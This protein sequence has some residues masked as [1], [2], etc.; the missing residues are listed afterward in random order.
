M[1]RMYFFCATLSMMSLGA[2]AQ[3]ALPLSVDEDV[4]NADTIFV[5]KTRVEWNSSANAVKTEN[6]QDGGYA[7]FKFKDTPGMLHLDY[8]RTKYGKDRVMMIQESPDGQNFSD[9]YNGD[10]STSWTTLASKLKKDTRYIKLYYDAKYTFGDVGSRMAYW[11]DINVTEPIAAQAKADTIDVDYGVKALKTISV[12]YSNP[13]G[14]IIVSSSD[15]RI[16]FGQE[17]SNTFTIANVA[18]TEGTATVDVYYDSS[19]EPVAT[20]EISSVLT[21]AD[22]GNEGYAKEYK[23]VERVKAPVV[24][25]ETEGSIT[26]VVGQ[27]ATKTF[28]V[29]YLPSVSPDNVSVVSSREDVAVSVE[30]SVD[31][32]N[33]LNV[34]LTYLP[35]EVAD[36]AEAKITVSESTSGL[37]LAYNLTVN[38]YS[39]NNIITN[40]AEYNKFAEIVNAGFNVNAELSNDIEFSADEP[41]VQ[42][43]SFA[44]VFDGKFHKINGYG[45][46]DEKALFGN[47]TSFTGTV[48]NLCVENVALLD[49]NVEGLD[50]NGNGLAVECCYGTP[51]DNGNALLMNYVYMNTDKV[52]NC[53]T[54]VRGEEIDPST[55]VGS[56]VYLYKLNDGSLGMLEADMTTTEGMPAC[57]SLWKQMESSAPAVFGFKIGT[58]EMPSFLAADNAVST[59]NYY[60]N[61]ANATGKTI[62]VQGGQLYDETLAS[63]KFEGKKNDFVVLNEDSETLGEDGMKALSDNVVTKDGKAHK[64]VLTDGED[65]RFPVNAS[66][67]EISADSIEYSRSV[68]F[69]SYNE[70]FCLPFDITSS[71]DDS[72]YGFHIDYIFVDPSKPALREDKDEITLQSTFNY[73]TYNAGK[74]GSVIPAGTPFY[75]YCCEVLPTD[76]TVSD[77]EES[78]ATFVGENVSLKKDV[79]GTNGKFAP[80]FGTYVNSS[81]ADLDSDDLLT[82]VLADVEDNAEFM[83][84][85][86]RPA[87]DYSVKAFRVYALL[88]KSVSESGLKSYKVIVDDGKTS[89]IKIVDNE[90]AQSASAVYDL[91]G[92]RVTKM[93]DGN[94]YMQN[95]RKFVFMAK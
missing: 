26:T 68:R 60:T 33:V 42:I 78:V 14:D 91:M 15:S 3:V 45:A 48:K 44:G 40:V 30:P 47:S 92:R 39:A 79:E 54:R 31:A 21:V 1:K 52:K 50:E 38:A 95:G 94:I 17:G 58:D 8:Q 5:E 53:F 93:T 88:D 23:I 55:G 67:Q 20:G 19:L 73:M 4:F 64:I 46:S 57:F 10:P 84:D 90:N 81:V 65:Y 76:G 63:F 18:G 7:V 49:A 2:S 12:S 43:E 13:S 27:E 11:R 37:S 82:Y 75:A 72:K 41:N 89:G 80:L 32:E 85:F 6:F 77:T 35:Q 28:S 25:S 9:L 87:T 61:E 34:T 62:Y 83:G 51:S 70:S 59:A 71:D 22:S 16:S 24:L 86:V 56:P 29:G 74:Y 69:N 36:N 66:L